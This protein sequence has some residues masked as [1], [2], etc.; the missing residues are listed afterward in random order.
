MSVFAKDVICYDKR[1]QI[2]L[3]Y[4]ENLTPLCGLTNSSVIPGMSDRLQEFI[5]EVL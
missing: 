4:N 2:Y 5:K 3:K 1:C